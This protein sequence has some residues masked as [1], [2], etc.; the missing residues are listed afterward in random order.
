MNSSFTKNKKHCW[1][2]NKKVSF[3]SK[4]KWKTFVTNETGYWN[5]IKY[6]SRFTFQ[7]NMLPVNEIG[8]LFLLSLIN[9]L[10]LNQAL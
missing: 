1:L 2:Q 5:L 9:S 3:N 7:C 4:K 10:N 8:F 6:E